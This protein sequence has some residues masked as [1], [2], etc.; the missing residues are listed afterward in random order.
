MW[1]RGWDCAPQAPL[2]TQTQPGGWELGGDL[3]LILL[4]GVRV[5]RALRT[6]REIGFGWVY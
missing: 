1:G 3:L 4:L 2:W 6:G 5:G